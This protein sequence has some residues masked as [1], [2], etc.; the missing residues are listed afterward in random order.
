MSFLRT[1]PF[2]EGVCLFRTQ[3]RLEWEIV[4]GGSSPGKAEELP[5]SHSSHILGF[6]HLAH[7]FT[8]DHEC[9][10]VLRFLRDHSDAAKMRLQGW[11]PTSHTSE[12]QIL[13]PRAGEL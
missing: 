10:V 2:Q 1:L 4:G 9:V 12:D 7:S 3:H 5:K 6:T 11:L 8:R 13:A